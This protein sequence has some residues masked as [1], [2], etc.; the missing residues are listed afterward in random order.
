MRE[1]W[2]TLALVLTLAMLLAAVSGCTAKTDVETESQ[3]AETAA[4]TAEEVD[5]SDIPG[6]EDETLA[7]K[8]IEQA[9]HPLYRH[10]R[11]V[12]EIESD[13]RQGHSGRRGYLYER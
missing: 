2:K 1:F 8:L 12:S 9:Q 5:A 13:D 7:A 10:C 4:P 6:V 3:Q 11:T